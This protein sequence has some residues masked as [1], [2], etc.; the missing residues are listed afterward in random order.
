MLFCS[1][2]ES[3][4]PKVSYAYVEKLIATAEKNY[5]DVAIKN[6]ETL[7]AKN[8]ITQTAV[9]WFDA[10]NV[11]YYYRPNRAID[12][13]D[14]NLFNG[15]QLGVSINLGTLLQKPFA[16]KEAKGKYKV[17]QLTERK[18]KLTLTEQ[19]KERYF[20]YVEQ[21]TQLKLRTQSYTDAQTLVKQL[22]YKYEKG[23]APFDDYQRALLLA[24]EQNQFMI[25]AEAGVFTTKA[26]LE[27][28]LGDKLENIK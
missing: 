4:L 1:A 27:E 25:H 20:A 18:Y 10:F 28:L 12:I 19:I 15:Y 14:P 6:Q 26:A 11:S 2:Q 7:I 24:T 16:T 9:S 23:E 13:V 21:L 5:P 17:T 22:R 3:I 8:N